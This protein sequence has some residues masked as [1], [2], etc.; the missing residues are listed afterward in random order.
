MQ[1]LSRIAT[2]EVNAL[3]GVWRLR[4]I[5][6]AWW[7]H[8]QVFQGANTGSLVE[9]RANNSTTVRHAQGRTLMC[10]RGVA[11]VT[12]LGVYDDY[13]LHPGQSLRTA[14]RGSVVVTAVEDV[15]LEIVR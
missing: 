7:F 15:E 13:V 5:A 4:S 2:Y 11:W 3:T 10:K 9:L 6:V 1:S 12:Q 14:P 8:Q